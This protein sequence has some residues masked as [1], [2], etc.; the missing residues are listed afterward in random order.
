MQPVWQNQVIGNNV[1]IKIV[2]IRYAW[3]ILN[4][5]SIPL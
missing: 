5:P 2:S 3:L 1:G 4:S